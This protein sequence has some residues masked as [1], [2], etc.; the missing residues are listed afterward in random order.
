MNKQKTWD[1]NY[2]K[3]DWRGDLKHIT[4]QGTMIRELQRLILS[5]L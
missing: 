3:I 4:K 1:T 2:C 5:N